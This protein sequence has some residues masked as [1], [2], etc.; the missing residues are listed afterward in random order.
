MFRF[1]VELVT[2]Q[3][4][5]SATRGVTWVTWVNHVGRGEISSCRQGRPGRHGLHADSSRGDPQ[6]STYHIYW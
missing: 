4:Q 6:V 5:D 2:G 1:H 3:G